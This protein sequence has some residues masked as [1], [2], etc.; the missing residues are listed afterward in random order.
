MTAP[1]VQ[2]PL[3]GARESGQEFSAVIGESAGMRHA[4][5]MARRVATTPLRT[6]LLTGEV[7]TGKELLARCIHNAGH[8]ANAPFVAINCGSI[9]GPL[10]EVELFGAPARQGAQ[11]RLGALE[12][13]GRGTVFLDD[14][15]E[16]PMTLQERLLHTLE[17][18]SIPR[19]GAGESV[20]HC[21]VIASSKSRLE[22][23]VSAGVFREA[24]AA[25]LAVLRIELPPLRERDDDARLIA[26][27]LLVEAT[28]LQGAPRRQLGLDA[29]AVLRGHRWPGNVREL[30]H[31]IERA[32][33]VCE[34]SLIGAEHLMINQRRQGA[35]PVRG[36][37]NFGEI[38]IPVEGKRLRDI[39]KEALEITMQLTDYNQ[40]AA[41]RILCISR[42]TLARKLRTYG[43]ATREE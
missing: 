9:P 5:H 40:S 17:D 42:P 21:R 19:L 4:L 39:E 3:A 12:L 16:L 43:L 25:R 29:A 32:M 41:S 28:R 14:V 18:Y 22:E 13:A 24:L 6:L 27:H 38:R 7:G 2:R 10:L 36:A 37:A 35:G 33:V 1:S 8:F 23:R 11:R 31:V 26:D 15:G 20:V 30:K 34:T